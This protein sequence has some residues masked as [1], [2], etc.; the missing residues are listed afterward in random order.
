M[1]KTI[2]SLGAA[3]DYQKTETVYHA[4]GGATYKYSNTTVLTAQPAP[5]MDFDADGVLVSSYPETHFPAE[6][7]DP[8]ETTGATAIAAVSFFTSLDL[9]DTEIT[10]EIFDSYANNTGDITYYESFVSPLNYCA[11]FRND[12]IATDPIEVFKDS[13]EN[14]H[15][16][17]ITSLAGL[18]Y[19]ETR[20]TLSDIVG[21]IASIVVPSSMDQSVA[22]SL[23]FIL[24]V[25]GDSPDLLPQ[26]NIF[27]RTFPDKSTVTP[28]G[29]FYNTFAQILYDSNTIVERGT[30][31]YK[32]LLTNPVLRDFRFETDS[33]PEI[34]N[35]SMETYDL[36]SSRQRAFDIS[37]SIWSR[38]TE[39][40]D[41]Q[42]DE[43]NFTTVGG[44]RYYDG[45]HYD[46]NFIDQGYVFFN[47]ERAIKEDS[48][49]AEIMS[50]A[51]FERYFGQKVT[52]AAYKIRQAKVTAI[53]DGRLYQH[54]DG[55]KYNVG[56]SL[57]APPDTMLTV[58]VDDTPAVN[59][60]TI[61]LTVGYPE[62][63]H[64]TSL[65]NVYENINTTAGGILVDDSSED[66]S[67][68]SLYEG[69]H[70]N[71]AVSRY[72]VVL[73]STDGG[74]YEMDFDWSEYVFTASDPAL[75]WYDADTAYSSDNAEG[76][77]IVDAYEDFNELEDYIAAAAA[78][79]DLTED[80]SPG[81]GGGP[82]N[83]PKYGGAEFMEDDIS[84]SFLALR[85][86]SPM[87]ETEGGDALEFDSTFL[88]GD[89]IHNRIMCFEYKKNDHYDGS[90]ASAD[91]DAELLDEV[92]LLVEQKILTFILMR[93]C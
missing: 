17:V 70:F 67:A 66:G 79:I 90:D 9:Y 20:I 43:R 32:A 65:Y 21:S 55:S 25:Y 64:P 3:S 46:Y 37:K 78:G 26:L 19:A 23:S 35:R 91:S 14:Y 41:I 57:S 13:N 76:S 22:D 51:A 15:E 11:I 52:N 24:S 85:G 39:I 27:R 30:Q 69:N 84:F 50:V 89:P 53:Y 93:G 12:V 58:G 77:R 75:G 60:G 29:Q 44:A 33:T 38:W 74:A 81:L 8:T 6:L 48:F 92:S 86:W 88:A 82:R 34:F 18:Y 87:T 73:E 47:Y 59:V 31:V 83:N 61:I 71:V 80:A 40:M 28:T 68:G 63:K 4:D 54:A 72:P 2:W 62:G 5:D 1:S 7:L 49:L 42:S 36:Q 10:D 45:G 56:D 16:L